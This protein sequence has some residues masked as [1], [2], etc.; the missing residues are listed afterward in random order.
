VKPIGSLCFIILAAC[1]TAE[2]LL[3][4]DEVQDA[5][6]AIAVGQHVCGKSALPS[7]HWTAELQERIWHVAQQE[8]RSWCPARAVE[9]KAADGS[10]E[11]CR[12]CVGDYPP[13]N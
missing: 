12:I 11:D 10:T 2:T 13:S 6:V 8:F 9:V 5:K 4:S 3:P 7:D 1:A